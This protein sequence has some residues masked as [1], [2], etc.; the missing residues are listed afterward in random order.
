MNVFWQIHLI[1]GVGLFVIG[2]V[3]G[4]FLNVCIYRI[5]WEKSVI[6]PGS[7][8]PHCLATIR[9]RDNLPVLGWLMLGGACRDCKA[10]ISPRYPAIEALVGLL[11]L[12]VYLVDA[13][14]PGDYVRDDGLLL[15]K[16]AYHILLVALLV[17]ITF[18]DADLTIVPASITNL[19]ILI[20]LGLG[21]AFPAIRPEPA[22]ALTA[23]AGLVVGV[24]GLVV[25]A[26]L[27][28]IVRAVGSFVFR[29]EAMGSGDIHILGMVGAFLGW[30]AAIATFFLAPFFGFLPA[31]LKYA[32]YLAK[33]ITGR[34][35]TGGDREI[36]F[37]P[38]LS[39]AALTLLFGWPWIWPGF[40]KNYFETIP[41]LF[42]FL[43]G[44]DR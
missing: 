35:V 26:G 11:F 24:K 15:A 4:S 7:H 2:T 20:G 39:A 38:C 40:L 31:I 14:L 21:A 30:Q 34:K 43:M 33:L 25:G 32:T 13:V 37:G 44:M 42:W 19:G 23:W 28:A 12:G 22:S 8:C 17:A 16:L 41:V 6:W 1:Y 3:V 29:R 36:P 18:I 9:T 27:I 10:P 5:P